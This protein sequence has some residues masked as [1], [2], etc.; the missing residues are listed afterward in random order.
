MREISPALQARLD[1]GATTLAHVWIIRRQDGVVQGF[2]DHDR[3]ITFHQVLCHAASGLDVSE[4]SE[5]LGMSTSGGEVAGALSHDAISET[6]IL[7]GLYD[8]ASVELYLVDWSQPELH[9]PLRA[10]TIG[11]ITREDQAFKA[12]LRSLAHKLDQEQGRRYTATCAANLGDERCKVAVNSASYSATATITAM[13]ED[14]VLTVSGLGAFAE[15]WFTGGRLEVLSGESK[16]TSL[17]IDHHFRNGTDVM[18]SP[19]GGF[20]RPPAVGDRLKVIAGCDKRAVTCR[21]KFANLVNF[22]GFP[23]MPGNDFVVS[24]PIPGEAGHDG[25]SQGSLS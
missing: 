16:G 20:V 7:A 13:D 3:D 15:G 12:E 2:T 6:D 1:S 24:Y 19:W 21:D 17:E 11:E 4:L 8:D 22:R 25:S 10:M 9:V 14:G 18:L 23:S 5:R